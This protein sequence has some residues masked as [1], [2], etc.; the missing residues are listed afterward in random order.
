V[1]HPVGAAAHDLPPPQP[2]VFA[3]D[4]ELEEI[5]A[6]AQQLRKQAGLPDEPTGL[7]RDESTDL[8]AAL[9]GGTRR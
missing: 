6:I 8:S 2:V 3:P 1:P 4:Y 9:A 7:V 5:S